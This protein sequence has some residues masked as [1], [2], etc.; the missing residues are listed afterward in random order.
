MGFVRALLFLSPQHDE[1]LSQA[2]GISC[3]LRIVAI[4]SRSL[5]GFKHNRTA[6]GFELF[7]QYFE[8]FAFEIDRMSGSLRL[9]SIHG[10]RLHRSNLLFSFPG[11]PTS[12]S[13][14]PGSS[15]V[16]SAPAAQSCP[17]ILS[18]PLRRSA[19]SCHVWPGTRTHA[20]VDLPQSSPQTSCRIVGCICVRI[21][22]RLSR[23]ELSKYITRHGDIHLELYC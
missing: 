5:G 6:C 19:S 21:V 8:A 11:I 18:T 4:F 2:V 9:T 13:L 1:E 10:F 17:P 22:I 12:L 7:W 15:L 20:A 14:A 16:L 3:P 23:L